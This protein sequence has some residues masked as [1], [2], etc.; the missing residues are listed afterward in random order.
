MT[1]YYFLSLLFVV[2][3]L[4]AAMTDLKVLQTDSERTSLLK[5]IIK[6]VTVSRHALFSNEP[7]ILHAAYYTAVLPLLLHNVF[8]SKPYS[9]IRSILEARQLDD[10]M[11]YV[12][13]IH[14]QIPLGLSVQSEG[15][16][17]R[18]SDV[19]CKGNPIP[20]DF[21]MYFHADSLDALLPSLSE[22]MQ[23]HAKMMFQEWRS[24]FEELQCTSSLYK[25]M[26]TPS[27]FREDVSPVAQRLT[28]ISV[29]LQ[30]Q[31]EIDH[32]HTFANHICLF[33]LFEYLR[34]LIILIKDSTD[35]NCFTSKGEWSELRKLW[36]RFKSIRYS[37]DPIRLLYEDT[38][39][40]RPLWHLN[41]VLYCRKIADARPIQRIQVRL[42]PT[43]GAAYAHAI[44]HEDSILIYT[45]FQHALDLSKLIIKYGVDLVYMNQMFG[46]AMHDFLNG[47]KLNY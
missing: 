20:P 43:T 11:R 16:I 25:Y 36:L 41:D 31:P 13:T 14:S 33:R 26:L 12:R 47:I 40:Q 27:I 15:A 19:R 29:L 4:G 22:S 1:S 28:I 2:T 39:M 6:A 9:I 18:R 17:V 10:E 21:R 23:F 3:A 45:S 42:C 30:I 38:R 44:I 7:Y 35:N 32:A 46:L 37:M 34:H 8:L 24:F 5:E